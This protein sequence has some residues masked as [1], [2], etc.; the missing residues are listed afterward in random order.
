[1]NEREVPRE[2]NQYIISSQH[3]DAVKPVRKLINE[4]LP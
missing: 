2:G 4:L 1:V 3:L